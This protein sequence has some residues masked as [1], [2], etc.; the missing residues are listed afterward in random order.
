MTLDSPMNAFNRL[1]LPTLGRPMMANWITRSSN[2]IA[3][4]IGGCLFSVMDASVTDDDD[5]G[6]GSVCGDDVITSSI[7]GISFVS[8]LS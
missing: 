8:P 4:L 2:A 5:V 1:D 6:A 7:F 3:L